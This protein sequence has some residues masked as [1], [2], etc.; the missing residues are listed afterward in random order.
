M[1]SESDN[2][3]DTDEIG[4][5]VDTTELDGMFTCSYHLETEE[6]VSLRKNYIL[7]MDVKKK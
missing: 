6:A 5:K 4:D 7:S 1:F 3:S 2:E